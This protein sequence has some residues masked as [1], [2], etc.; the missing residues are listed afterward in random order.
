MKLHWAAAAVCMVLFMIQCLLHTLLPC[1]VWLASRVIDVHSR[2]WL[3][4]LSRACPGLA[5]VRMTC[6]PHLCLR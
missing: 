1:W 6:W 3:G 2:E 4:C 5:G